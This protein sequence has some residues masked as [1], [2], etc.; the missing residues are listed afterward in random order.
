MPALHHLLSIESLDAGQIEDF[1]QLGM[2]LKAAR[3]HS[4][5]PLPLRGQT[6]ALIF[7]KSSTRTR[8]SFEVGIQE[9][10]GTSLFL[11]MHDIQLG[12][13]ETVEDTAQVLSRYIHGVVIRTYAQA[14]VETFA[15]VGSIP[16]INALTDE[17]H[18]CQILADLM[19]WAECLAGSKRPIKKITR[20]FSGKTVV[21]FGDAD[22]NVARSWLFAADKLGFNLRLAAPKDYRPNGALLNRAR[23]TRASFFDD[24]VKAAA[25]AHLLYTDTWVSMGKE[26]E[27][28][29]RLR[30]LA[31]FQINNRVVQAAKP[32][33]L[34]MHC[35]PA[36]RGQEIT[37]DVF[38]KHAQTIFDQAE[39]R[40]HL[41]KAVLN[42]LAK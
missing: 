12:R 17:E 18:P 24:P 11:G 34:V 42:R 26:K 31:P 21:F 29:K 39:N 38:E 32:G 30:K 19:T 33:A 15:R 10:G 7:G 9:L 35:L 4:R 28:N 25:G 36:Y 14:D 13:G 37:A 22:C 16:V 23:A 3:Q 41:Q 6:W 40:L 8:V 1:L 5:N 20:L 27:E 2:R